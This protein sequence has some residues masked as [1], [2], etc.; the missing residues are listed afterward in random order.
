MALPRPATPAE[1][2]ITD[3]PRTERVSETGAVSS[4]QRAEL[5]MPAETLEGLWKP[6]TLERLARAYW[7]YLNRLSLG[8]LRVVYSPTGRT[9]VLL[10]RPFSLLRFKAP[11]YEFT[12]RH[13]TVT[14]QIDRGLLVAREGRGQGFLRISIDRRPDPGPARGCVAVSAEV[15]NFYPWL[16]GSG[17]FARFGTWLYSHTQVRVHVFVTYGFL[18]SLARLELPPTSVG[19]LPGEIAAGALPDA[20]EDPHDLP[21]ERVDR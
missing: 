13:G 8:L 21:S 19:V 14:W 17:R 9:V 12:P 11:E 5:E 3:P 18:R 10:V 16:R 4:V 20:E 1:V 6:A 15:R 2:R 7:R